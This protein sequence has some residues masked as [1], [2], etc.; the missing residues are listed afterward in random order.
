MEHGA[1]WNTPWRGGADNEER[2]DEVSAR[3]LLSPPNFRLR[4][5]D[6]MRRSKYE[7]C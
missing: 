1:C 2:K 6:E 3:S 4:S 5:P 7:R